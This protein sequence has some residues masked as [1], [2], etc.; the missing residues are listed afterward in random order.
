MKELSVT[1]VSK[2]MKNL[3]HTLA[4]YVYSHHNICNIQI[5]AL[6]AYV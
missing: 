1:Y 3:E 2:Q 6:A 4:S 5:K